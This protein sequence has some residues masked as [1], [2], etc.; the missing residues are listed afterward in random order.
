[1]DKIIKQY[2]E[3][4]ELQLQKQLERFFL[5]VYP[6]NR[7]I[8]HGIAHHRRVWKH[9]KELIKMKNDPEY[10]SSD[11]LRNLIAACYLHDIGMAEDHGFNHGLMGKVK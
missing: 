2:I 11:F 10:L 4:T 1:M 9:A 5:S 7:L 6:E 8:S 3:T